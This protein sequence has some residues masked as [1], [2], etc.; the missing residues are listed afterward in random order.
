LACLITS[1]TSFYLIASDNAHM[2]ANAILTIIPLL[3]TY[4]YPDETPPV[5]QLLIYWG[6]FSMLTL[7]DPSYHSVR[8]YYFVKVVLLSLLFLRPFDGAEWIARHIQLLQLQRM[9]SDEITKSQRLHGDIFT[10][11]E[12]QVMERASVGRKSPPPE[13][14]ELRFSHEV[15]RIAPISDANRS[16]KGNFIEKGDAL[17]RSS[18]ADNLSH[19]MAAASSSSTSFI[20]SIDAHDLEFKPTYF[21]VFNGPFT[22]NNLSCNIQIRNTCTRTIAFAV[23]TNALERISAQPPSGI[24]KPQQTLHV[25]I[26]LKQFKYSASEA[27]RMTRDRVKFEY[28]YCPPETTEFSH[29]LLQQ[30]GTGDIRRNKNIYIRYNP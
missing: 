22:D 29:K 8:G 14:P 17:R 3:L 27:E 18:N 11:D 2:L 20:D 5:P 15:I 19:E 28:V 13:P 9:P 21:L 7:L 1:I 12:I 10:K 26:T 16:G 25:A 23:K 30:T 4:L 24:I 6:A